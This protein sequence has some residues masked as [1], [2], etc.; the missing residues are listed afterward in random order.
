[1]RPTVPPLQ[2]SNYD[3]G[4]YIFDH[5]RKSCLDCDYTVSYIN[6]LRTHMLIHSGEKHFICNERDHFVIYSSRGVLFEIYIC[7]VYK[8]ILLL[9]SS[10]ISFYVICIMHSQF[11]TDDNQTLCTFCGIPFN[12]I[13]KCVPNKIYFG[14]YFKQFLI[15][16]SCNFCGIYTTYKAY[17]YSVGINLLT[18]LVENIVKSPPTNLL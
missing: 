3:L 10:I 2:H 13:N 5:I 15:Y 12:C 9:Y 14:I 8:H 4:P 1:M 6:M 18:F 7:S 17:I 16:I 11:Y